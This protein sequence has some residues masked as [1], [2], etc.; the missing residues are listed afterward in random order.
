M[1]DGLLWYDTTPDNRWTNNQSETPYST[2]SVTLPR[3][4]E[5]NSVSLAVYDDTSRGGVIACPQAVLVRDRNGTALASRNPWTDC[6]PNALNTILFSAASNDSSNATT[7]ATGASTETDF[8]SITL[9]NALYYSVAL[10]EIQIWVPSN[11]GPRYEVED[12]LLGTF[13]GSFEG[14]KSGLNCTLQDGGVLFGPGGWAEVAN[15]RKPGG[16]AGATNLTVIGG[17]NG[18]LTV[19][20]NFLSKETVTFDGTDANKTVEINLLEGGNVVTLFQVGGEPW[21][22]AF[23]VG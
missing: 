1:I 22:D 2:I 10:T 3:P 20:M 17:G 12:G 9:V 4:R 15:V 7:L 16:G 18:T 6:T 5:I 23:V 14:R 8:L 21:V 19:Q 11:P 13:I